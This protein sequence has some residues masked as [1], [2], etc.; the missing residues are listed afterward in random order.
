MN[1]YYN[2]KYL[3]KIRIFCRLDKILDVE[4]YILSTKKE[5]VAVIKT[6]K[7]HIAVRLGIVPEE[8]R[9]RTDHILP[10][11]RIYILRKP[12]FTEVSDF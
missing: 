5:N 7:P 11:R 6:K 3:S 12:Y 8:Y 9:L 2:V 10:A 1:Y 4:F